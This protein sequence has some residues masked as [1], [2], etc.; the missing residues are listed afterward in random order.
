M[1][2]FQP[3]S[4]KEAKLMS[5]LL[6]C[7]DV[8]RFRDL[9]W[10]GDFDIGGKFANDST[11]IPSLLIEGWIPQYSLWETIVFPPDID[12]HNVNVERQFNLLQK[13]LSKYWGTSELDED[14]RKFMEFKDDENRL[15]E[16]IVEYID[17]YVMNPD[18]SRVKIQ[19]VT[20]C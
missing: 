7:D 5:S 18:D 4:R 15:D 17:L 11:I 1:V 20:A 19:V 6:G 2:T 14:E 9:G 16:D 10:E 13:T 12:Y 3:V 8:E